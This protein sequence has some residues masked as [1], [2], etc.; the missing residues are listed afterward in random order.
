[1]LI[2]ACARIAALRVTSAYTIEIPVRVPMNSLAVKPGPM[3]RVTRPWA[4]RI[5]LIAALSA[6]IAWAQAQAPAGAD[7]YPQKTVKVLV[8]FP[9]G[10]LPDTVSRLIQQKLSERWGQPVLTE[11][12]PGA[13]GAVA[14]EILARAPADGHTLYI[15]DSSV[16]SIYPYLHTKLP[17]RVEDYTSVSLV[18]RAPLFLAVNP[19]LPVANMAELIALARAKP[20]QLF[21]G[22]SGIGSLHHLGM[23]ALKSALGLDIVHV[24]Y[25]GSSESVPA[26][27]SGQVQMIFSAGPAL[28]NHAKDGRVRILAVNS[29]TRSPLAPEV[30][31][32][33]E[34]G[35][36]GYDFAPTLGYLAPTGTPQRVTRKIS[37]DLA[38][39]VKL[40]EITRR[41]AA[42]GIEAVG[43]T[44]EEQTEQWRS[45]AE[46][47]SLVIKRT[48]VKAE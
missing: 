9:P 45:D 5:L 7:D 17:Y 43:S 44:P 2:P 13:G 38:D 20:G 33:A 22:S 39:V 19:S 26:L 40:P 42:L 35:I 18:A 29:A 14:A 3:R 48:G 8:G 30:P 47:Y 32:V 27:L 46:R 4:A 15:S 23:E 37:R 41:F 24:A 6:P 12:R 25:K 11:N 31:T 28:A 21:Y 34:S 1:M 36:P 10:G 16:I